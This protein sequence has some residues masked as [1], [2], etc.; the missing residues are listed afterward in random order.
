[1][2]KHHTAPHHS[3]AFAKALPAAL[4]IV[5]L[6]LAGCSGGMPGRH[7]QTTT[8]TVKRDP[9]AAANPADHAGAPKPGDPQ[10]AGGQRSPQDY[11]RAS[12]GRNTSAAFAESV[13]QQFVDQ[14]V[15]DGNTNVTVNAYSPVTGA[16]YTMS[17]SGTDVVH[18]SGG[19]DA[20]VYIYSTS[21]P[22]DGS[23]PAA[24]GQATGGGSTQAYSGTIRDLSGYEFANTYPEKNGNPPSAGQR[25]L[26]LEL[27]APT[28]FTAELISAPGKIETRTATEIRLGHSLG[29]P[30][31]SAYAGR[32]G[33]HVTINIDPSTCMW[34]SDTTPPLGAPFCD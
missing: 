9:N 25:V 23:T 3:V 34:P 33:E 2:R 15:K 4:S 31:S 12:A 8:V 5:A 11:P 13:R 18:C 28:S 26:F 19:N 6:T 20:H 24:G 14:W 7:A 16:T 29:E 27:D 10:A 1:M 21:A 30:L 17:C 22:T 32:N